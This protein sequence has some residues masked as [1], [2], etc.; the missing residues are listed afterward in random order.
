MTDPQ[1]VAVENFSHVCIGVSDMDKSL[2]FYTAVLGMDV[3]F[4]VE[5]E[6]AALDAVTAGAAQKGRMVGGL[7]G[8][9]MVELL[10]LGDVPAGHTGPHLGYTKMSFRVTDLDDTYETLAESASRGAYRPTCRH[11]WCANVL[12]LRPR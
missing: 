11:R 3:V 9:A 8:G 5:L 1:P 10:F 2:A 4:D 12:R 7:I 6:G